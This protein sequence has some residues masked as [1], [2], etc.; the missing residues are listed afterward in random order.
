[1]VFEGIEIKSADGHLN[2]LIDEMG[3][4]STKRLKYLNIFY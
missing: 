4:L 3:M 1:M 2:N